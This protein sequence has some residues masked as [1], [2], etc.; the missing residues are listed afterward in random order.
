MGTAMMLTPTV[1]RLLMDGPGEAL[2]DVCLAR[3]C[4]VTLTEMRSI[5]RGLLADHDFRRVTRC[6]SCERDVPALVYPARPRNDR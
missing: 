6:A 4:M 3:A 5:T 1:R 2:C